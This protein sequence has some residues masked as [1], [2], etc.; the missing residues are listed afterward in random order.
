M[1]EI[2]SPPLKGINVLDVSH[3]LAGPFRTKILAQLG[4]RVIKVEMPGAGDDSRAFGPFA[5]GKSLYFS[6][7]NYDKQ[8]IALN[9]KHVP[10]RKVFEGLVGIADVLV[11]NFRPGTMEKLGCGWE[12][13]RAKYPNLIY[14]YDGSNV[15]RAETVAPSGSTS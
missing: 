15:R 4:A 9:L 5:N 8:S 14:Q 1:Q 11:E 13:L 7:I 12:S 10:D 2:Q 6:A 3:V